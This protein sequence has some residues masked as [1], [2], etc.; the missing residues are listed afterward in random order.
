MED[1]L[2]ETVVGVACGDAFTAV[3]CSSG[4]VVHLGRAIG[5]MDRG[6]EPTNTVFNRHPGNLLGISLFLF[7][8]YTL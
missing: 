8:S 2:G 5:S 7:T 4:A 3:V 1:L 6:P